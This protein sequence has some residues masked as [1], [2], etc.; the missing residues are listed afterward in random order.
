MNHLIQLVDSKIYGKQD[1][2]KN[3]YPVSLTI[4]N[5][6]G[7]HLG[8][9]YLL[10]KLKQISKQ[11]E[12][13]V[14]VTFDPHPFNYFHPETPKKLLLPLQERITHLLK[15]GADVVY[16]QKFE[17]SFA[18]LS[19][20][21]FCKYWLAFYFNIKN[22]FVGHDFCYGKERRGNFNHLLSFGK[23]YGWHVEQCAPLLSE[24][25]QLHPHSS[26]ISSS[27]IRAFLEEGNIESA[28][29]FLARLYSLSGTVVKGDQIGR[30]LG[31]PTAN[32]ETLDAF[33]PKFGVYICYV[34]IDDSGQLLP[35][36]MNCGKRPTHTSG[37]KLQ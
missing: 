10:Q 24:P 16:V 35:A 7:V 23:Q 1:V 37:L 12:F 34:E 20:D 21:D 29:E 9:Q 2:I 33:I 5:F 6:D 19:A 15:H 18:Q 31:F 26:S 30:K 4:G 28:N 3:K 14:V 36:V 8:H 32:I 25:N 13:I 11:N 22:I 17:K 27:A